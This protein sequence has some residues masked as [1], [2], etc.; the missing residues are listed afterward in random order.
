MANIV[1]NNVLH[2]TLRDVNING[3]FI[4]KNTAIV[5]Q[6]SALLANENVKNCII[7]I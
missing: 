3:Y 6:I 4:P 7:I 2:K 5:P 1:P